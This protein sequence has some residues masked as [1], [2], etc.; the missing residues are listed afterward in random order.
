M[1]MSKF[2]STVY[3]PPEPGLPPIAV[4][5]SD[6]GHVVMAKPVETRE[7]GE[8]FIARMQTDMEALREWPGRS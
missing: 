1:P 7:E 6:N 8:A 3:P 2:A 5:F 4:I